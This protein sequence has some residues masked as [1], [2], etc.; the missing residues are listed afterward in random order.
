MENRNLALLTDFYEFTM[1]NGAFLDNKINQEVVF[2]YFYRKNP[3]NGGYSIFAGLEQLVDF[4]K[5]LHFDD[6]DIEYLK[7]KSMFNEG[8]LAY[9]KNFKFTGTINAMKE[10]TIMYPN[11]PIITV[12]ATWGEAQLIETML[13]LTCNH[14]SLIATKASRIVRAAQGK[15]VMEFG[16]R[17][18]HSYDAAVLGARAAYIGGVDATATALADKE[19]GIPAIGTMAHSWIQFY[20]NDYDAFKVYAQA[21]PDNCTLLVDT[22]NVLKSGVPAAIKVAKEILEPQGKQLKGIRIDSGDL[23]YLSKAARK[24]LDR[25]DMYDCKIVVSNSIDEYLIKSLLVDQRAPI[26]SFGVG[27]RLITS[28][29]EPVFGG[30]YKLSA[31]KKDGIFEP[32]IKI[33]ENIEKTTNPGYTNVWRIYRNYNTSEKQAIADLISLYGEDFSYASG[34]TLYKPEMPALKTMHSNIRMI[35]LLHPVIERGEVIYDYP[36]LEE[37]R[38]FVKEQLDTVWVEELRF[39]NPHQ[40]YVNLS[41]K[42]YD[43]KKELLQAH[44]EK[45]E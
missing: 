9:L 32:R 14:Q 34:I 15:T 28:K 45:E 41:D 44:Y 2:T 26:D 22:Y 18:A 5:D 19:H 21:Y 12:V 13:L 33:S 30:V 40:H 43:L 10:G 4:I 6:S 20:D 36:N 35:K 37:I 17:R 23:A 3:E 1:A 27:E 25:A 29:S 7:E 31:V 24:M 11:E 42:L 39:E 8:F 16:A 38:K